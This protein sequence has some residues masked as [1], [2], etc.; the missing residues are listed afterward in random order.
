MEVSLVHGG[1]FR[2]WRNRSP[3][4]SC[5]PEGFCGQ[6]LVMHFIEILLGL[7]RGEAGLRLQATQ[8]FAR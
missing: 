7:L 4:Q 3:G 6:P 8:G 1:D 2:L 5:G